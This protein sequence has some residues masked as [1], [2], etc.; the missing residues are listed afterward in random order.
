ML[1]HCKLFCFATLLFA[2]SLFANCGPCGG[3]VY[4]GN[5]C[6]GVSDC[7]PGFGGECCNFG[8]FNGRWQFDIEFLYFLP[9]FDD[10]YFVIDD[11]NGGTLSGTRKN[12][13]FDFTP[14]FRIGAALSLCG[15]CDGEIEAFYTR[16]S[17]NNSLTISGPNLWAT[18]GS[19]ALTNAFESY[20]GNASS[21]LDFL[22]QRVDALYGH[23]LWCNNCADL[24]G[25][26]GLEW[27]Y[28]RFRE[29]YQFLT[30]GGSFAQINRSTKNWGIGPQFAMKYDYLICETSC[31]CPG[32]LSLAATSSASL[33]VSRSTNNTTDI[34]NG[35]SLNDVQDEKTW[36]IIP[37]LHA[38][39]GLNYATF[40]SCFGACVEVGYEFNSYLRG[41]TR[42]LFTDD[43]GTGLGFTN[44]YNFDVHGLYVA[45]DINF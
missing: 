3:Q 29:Q 43:V 12:N 15:C 23:Q 30:D 39:V 45:V 26:F 1:K 8:W 9:S 33:L 5:C 18:V 36:R 37:A 27:G 40:F 38:R 2:G 31:F 10:T 7:G 6:P 22:Y 25:M 21:T 28:I 44:Y 24:N 34:L 16:L 4:D 13:D 32:A 17:H 19:P 11:T 20:S 41:I 42:Q 35:A 14:G